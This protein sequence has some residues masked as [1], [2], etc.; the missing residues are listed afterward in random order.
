MARTHETE[1]LVGLLEQRDGLNSQLEELNKKIRALQQL[2]PA[3]TQEDQQQVA[4]EQTGFSEGHG[5]A[6]NRSRS[7]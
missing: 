2:R 6:Q 5:R 4:G 7:R 3:N 1:T